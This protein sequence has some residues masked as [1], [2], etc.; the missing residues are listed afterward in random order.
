MTQLFTSLYTPT[1]GMFDAQK[2]VEVA[3]N[4][5]ANANTEG[6]SRQRV[7]TISDRTYNIDIKGKIES[8]P[9]TSRVV[10][11]R[12]AF[13]DSQIRKESGTLGEF[14]SKAE[15]L[16]HV[17]T[18]FLEPSE[19]GLNQAMS[20]MWNSWQ[21]LSKNPNDD[22][23][24]T[25]VTQTS[26][27]FVTTLNYTSSR[28]SDMKSNALTEMENSIYNVNKALSQIDTLNGEIYKAKIRNIE[29]NELTDQRD[30]LLDEISKDISVQIDLDKY[31]RATVKSG[32]TELVSSDPTKK[33]LSQISF[34]NYVEKV[35]TDYKVNIS[36]AGD[37]VNNSKT[38]TISE[39]DYNQ[40]YS[41]Y[42]KEGAVIE[43]AK[44][45]VGE[46]SIKNFESNMVTGK[47]KGYQDSFELIQ[48]YSDSLDNLANSIATKINDIN[49]V[50]DGFTGNFFISETGGKITASSIRFNEEISG[51]PSKINA[52]STSDI[53]KTGFGDGTKALEILALQ[54]ANVTIGE[55]NNTTFNKFYNNLISSVGIEKQS[56][57]RMVSNEESLIT[58]L[59]TKRESVS[60]VSIDEEIANLVLFQN[61]YAANAKVMSTLVEMLDTLI[62]RTGL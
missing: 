15:L 36:L 46:A 18:A 47:I 59:E 44:D 13:V 55:S 43:T 56:A 37:G 39:S 4:N 34:V 32:T 11:I 35:G 1:K 57:D 2:R 14:E 26:E 7:E 27:N 23:T 40:K 19:N 12:D 31:G 60:G 16:G 51:N 48:K 49:P 6:Y 33:V 5:I 25:V 52:D 45:F 58:Q 10:R 8:G 28:L 38:L 24:K 61:S 53:T 17:E 21:E 20:D 42:L 30:L 41:T 29:P 62:N 3:S 22:S 50:E 9:N 54:N